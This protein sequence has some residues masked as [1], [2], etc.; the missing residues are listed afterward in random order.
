MRTNGMMA[1]RSTRRGIASECQQDSAIRIAV[2]R[3]GFDTNVTQ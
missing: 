1:S 3:N 2:T